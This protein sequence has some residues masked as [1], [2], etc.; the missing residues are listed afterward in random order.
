MKK[1]GKYIGVVLVLVLILYFIF[2][3]KVSTEQGIEYIKKQEALTVEEVQKSLKK[4][5][6]KEKIDLLNSGDVSAFSLFSDY[7]FYGDS[8]VV[9]FASYGFLDAN[10]IFASTGDSVTFMSNWNDTLTSLKPSYIIISYGANDVVAGFSVEEYQS[11]VVTSIQ[12][13][14]QL[15]PNAEIYVNSILPVSAGAIEENPAWNN[16]GSYNAMLK[17]VCKDNKWNYVDNDSLVSGNDAFYEPDGIHFVSSF[18]EIWA[19][20]IVRAIFS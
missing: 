20:N 13:V 19:D 6:K 12:E 14:E 10:R 5:D 8:R 2:G 11:M 1:Y 9:G 7:V 3:R 16:I 4:Q 15:C 17:Q 18:Y